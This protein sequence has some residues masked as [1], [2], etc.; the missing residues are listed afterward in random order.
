MIIFAH[1]VSLRSS[2]SFLH[3]VI[4]SGCCIAA[5]KYGRFTFEEFVNLDISDL[6]LLGKFGNRARGLWKPG[7]PRTEKLDA[8]REQLKLELKQGPVTK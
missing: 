3:I 7:E 2:C 6:E 5:D 4:I 8:L 1:F